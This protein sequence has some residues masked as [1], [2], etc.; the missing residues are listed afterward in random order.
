MSFSRLADSESELFPVLCNLKKAFAAELWIS[1]L[2]RWIWN[3]VYGPK[4]LYSTFT[5]AIAEYALFIAIAIVLI[6]DPRRNRKCT[7]F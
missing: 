2:P 5:L 6:A 7:A 3:E 1:L 4:Q